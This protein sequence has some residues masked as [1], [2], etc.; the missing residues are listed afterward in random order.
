MKKTDIDLMLKLITVVAERGAIKPDEFYTVA[1]LLDSL[2]A[3]LED[4]S[5]EKVNIS[6]PDECYEENDSDHDTQLELPLE[7]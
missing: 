7:Y 1:Q 5:S 2:K 6:E 3:E 4:T